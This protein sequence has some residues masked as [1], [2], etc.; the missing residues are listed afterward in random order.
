VGRAGRVAGPSA[1]L[2]LAWSAL[3]VPAP[4]RPSREAAEKALRES[5]QRFRALVHN[6]SDVF[7]VISAEGL[8]ATRAQ[9]SS[10]CSDIPPR[11]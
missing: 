9:P 1:I 8:V 7:T 4:P 5:E 2:A 11:S 6:A 3:A 10:R